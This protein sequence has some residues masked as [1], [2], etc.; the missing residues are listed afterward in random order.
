[1]LCSPAPLSNPV[2]HE[3]NY[4]RKRKEAKKKGML[5]LAARGLSPPRPTRQLGDENRQSEL[6]PD[7]VNMPDT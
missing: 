7:D 2:I 4:V 5:Y 3:H 1:M 6:S